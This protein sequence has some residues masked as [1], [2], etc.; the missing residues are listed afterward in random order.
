MLSGTGRDQAMGGPVENANK[1]GLYTPGEA[2]ITN[3]KRRHIFYLLLHSPVAWSQ[4]LHTGVPCGARDPRTWISS[5]ALV[6]QLGLESVPIL[7]A[8]ITDGRLAHYTTAPAH[9]TNL[10]WF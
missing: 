5:A 8:G 3:E 9:E 4:D 1:V 7:D 10:L 6:E 2:T